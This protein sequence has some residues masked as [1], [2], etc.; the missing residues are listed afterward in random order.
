MNNGPPSSGRGR[1]GKRQQQSLYSPGSGPLR[2]S[3]NSGSNRSLNSI[4]DGGPPSSRDRDRDRDRD[5]GNSDGWRSVNKKTNNKKHDY[6]DQRRNEPPNFRQASE[7]RVLST[8]PPNVSYSRPQDRLRNERDTRSL[9]P[10]FGGGRGGSS[11]KPPLPL[12]IES[13]P[14]RLQRKLLQDHGLPPDYLENLR[15]E[16]NNAHPPQSWS[17]TLPMSP[18]SRQGMRGGGGGGRNRFSGNYQPCNYQP[19]YRARTPVDYQ[20]PRSRSSDVAGEQDDY[21]RP[22]RPNSRNSSGDKNERWNSYGGHRERG[23]GF[24]EPPLPPHG[25]GGGGFRVERNRNDED[26]GRKSAGKFDWADDVEREALQEKTANSISNSVSNSNNINNNNTNNR[27][28]RRRNRSNSRS[29]NDYYDEGGFKM[30]YAPKGGMVGGGG[31]SGR[32]RRNSQS[33]N[34]SRENSMDRTAFGGGDRRARGGSFYNNREN[35]QD[36]F[37]DRGGGGGGGYSHRK[38][39]TA[40]GD[41]FGGSRDNSIDR[42]AG[43]ANWQRNEPGNWR[44]TNDNSGAEKPTDVTIAE[45]TKQFEEQVRIQKGPGVLVLPPKVPPPLGGGIREEHPSEADQQAANS[46]L[47]FDPKNPNKPIVVKQTLTRNYNPPANLNALTNASGIGSN[48]GKRTAGGSSQGAHTRPPWYDTSAPQAHLLRNKEMVRQLEAADNRLQELLLSGNLFREWDLYVQI[49]SD[50]Q[51]LLEAFLLSE[52][53]FSQDVNLEHHFWKLLYYNIIEQIRKLLAEDSDQNNLAYYREMALEIIENGTQ[54]FEH[55]LT[56]LEKQFCFSLESFIGLNAATNTKGVKCG[57]AL[58]SAQKVF[59][60]LGDLARYREQIN[61]SNNFRRAKQWYVKAQQIL[62][63]NGRPYNQL[64]LLSVYAK[65]KIDAVYFYMRSLM[66]SNPFESARESLM[67]LFNE[68]KKKYE[69]SQRKREEKIRARLKEKEHRFDGHLRRETWIHPEGGSR[70][71]RTAPLDPLAG[72]SA[73][74]TSEEEEEELRQLD[75]IELNKRFIVSFLHVLGKLITKTGMESFSPC[76]IQM[77]R[78]FRALIQHSPIAVTSHR[79]LQLMSLNMFSIEITKLKDE[80]IAPGARSEVQE[81]AL[82]IGLL[83]FGIILERFVHMIQ[84]ASEGLTARNNNNNDTRKNNNNN[85]DDTNESLLREIATKQSVI[86]DNLK[87]LSAVS[88]AKPSPQSKTTKN[89]RINDGSDHTLAAASPGNSID[90]TNKVESTATAA[91]AENRQKLVL[92]EDAKAILPAIKVWCDWMLYHTSTWNPPPFCTD[93]KIGASTGHDPWSGL[94]NLM[95]LLARLDTNKEILSVVSEADFEVV[96]LQEDITLAGFTPLMYDVPEPIFTH[97]D[98]DMEEAQNALRMQKLIFFGTGYLCK[99]D[100]PV[101][102]KVAT[103]AGAEEYLSIVQNRMEGSSDSE[104]LLESFSEDESESQ[105]QP[106]GS[107]DQEKTAAKSNHEQ[108]KKKQTHN[109]EEGKRNNN[110][111]STSKSKRRGNNQS[112]N[113]NNNNTNSNSGGNNNSCSN[114]NNNNN[115]NTNTSNNNNNKSDSVTSKEAKS[116]PETRKLLRRKDELERKQKMQEKYTQRLHDILSQS[117]IALHIEVRPRYLVPDTNCFVDYLRDI[118]S[119]AKA[120]PLYQLMV[121]IVVINELEGLS[122]GIKLDLATGPTSIITSKLTSSVS[123]LPVRP[124]T[125]SSVDRRYDPQHAEMVAVASKQALRFIKQKNPALKCVTT[126]G[127]ILKTSTFTSEDDV[128][129]QKSNDDRILET[130]LNLCRN[131]T[132]KKREE[133]RYLIREVVLLTTDRNLRV[134]ALSKD[135]PVR[136]LPDFI[137]W[138][139]L[140]PVES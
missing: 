52:M 10:S 115:N 29:S 131:H 14:P 26:E 48:E 81:C 28:N 15:N 41:W 86:A 6:Y 137:K 140:G 97:K 46:R 121:P 99:C 100:P 84:G 61:E 49:R 3:E 68:T 17:H 69:S 50:M 98:R 58:V 39:T 136:E 20:R 117:T 119:I 63:K 94:S 64:A 76:A 67:D 70:V 44:G 12:N 23:A 78:E 4:G 103:Q 35:S 90:G 36:R 74:D 33:S 133:V 138:A 71:H 62:P 96:R 40:G 139:G 114:N 83:M 128:G 75:S 82:S 135:L 111:N 91:G 13:L 109:E 16:Q 101:L 34:L 80:T 8:N 19:D 89:L 127:T 24:E 93:Y 66:S 73:A 65:R 43:G 37:Y 102:R 134:K 132:E 126:K 45:M 112:N 21:E 129:E 116:D 107:K 11:K 122:K 57:L 113:N 120:H 104:I 27:N 87:E 55:L 105:Q 124:P 51:K 2:K 53:R 118:E 31:S 123:V 72:Q 85:N 59:L 32:S 110:Y 108:Q 7:P 5:W 130:A 92:P 60:F 22:P 77:L 9:E 42:G 54:Y 38:K 106:M 95:T 1:G 25:A 30:P 79:L 88:T 56:L 125:S 18:R 47:L